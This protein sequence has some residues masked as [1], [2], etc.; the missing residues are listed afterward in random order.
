[1]AHFPRSSTQHFDGRSIACPDC[2]LLQREPASGEDRG[3]DC[4]R[5]GA[6][7]S[8]GIVHSPELTAS[9]A[10]AAAMMFCIGLS[11]PLMTLEAQGVVNTLT[12]F[13]V[14]ASLHESGM[15]L[16]AVLVALTI[17]VLPGIELV[18]LLYVSL[19]L[20]RGHVPPNFAR[21]WRWLDAIR[22]WAL[23]EVVMLGA[24]VSIG[25]LQSIGHLTLGA[26]FWSLAVMTLLL[27]MLDSVFDARSFWRRVE[28]LDAAAGDT[29]AARS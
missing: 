22:P 23:L 29:N 12:L 11:H 26:A 3:L 24:L 16:L 21:A 9:F 19:P 10:V 7:L 17:V 6:T 18:L 8:R 25:R 20:A 4:A 14:A 1:M 15:S 2:D 28:G 5:C 27:A 13:G